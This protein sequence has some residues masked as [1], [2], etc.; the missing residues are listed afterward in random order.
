[1]TSF[2]EEVAASAVGRFYEAAARPDLW[3][4]VLHETSLAFGAE[5][6]FLFAPKT[7]A[8]NAV[9]SEGIEEIV[10]MWTRGRWYERDRNP[11]IERS[12]AR[13]PWA[14]H[15]ENTIF[16]PEEIQR[17]P[18]NA[19]F[20]NQHGFGPFMAVYLTTPGPDAIVL[21]MERLAR[22]GGTT[23][24]SVRTFE[25]ILPH[26]RSAALLA[27]R[28]E[29]VHG[30]GMLDALE[31]I[32]CGALLL[33][34]SGCVIRINAKAESCCMGAG[35]GMAHG[36][37][38]S[39]HKGANGDLQRLLA[40]VLLPGPAHEPPAVGAVPIPRPNGRPLIAHAAPVVGSA[41][42]LFQSARAILMLV[43]PDEHREPAEP[44]LQQAFGL[45]PA[46]AQLAIG[47]ARGQDLLEIARARNVSIGTARNQFKTIFAKT[48]THRQSE[49]TA[50]L[51]RMGLVAR[52]S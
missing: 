34:R 50:L 8:I 35:L 33:D 10:E 22:R 3:R 28:L 32:G 7:A 42:D 19:E 43:D 14:I 24:E 31:L 29:D 51:N 25:T 23:S 26:L 52:R 39:E 30:Q 37:L 11:R 20:V 9:S 44:I 12:L 16:S 21:S 27:R 47:V 18:F 36:H 48:E 13:T 5:G 15:T 49:L 1:M 38:F 4:T 17:H 2:Q 41:C 45:T 6:A 40:S 46:E